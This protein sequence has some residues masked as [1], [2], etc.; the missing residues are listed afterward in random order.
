L[1]MTERIHVIPNGAEP[2]TERTNV[3]ADSPRIGFIG[4]FFFQPN[5]D[6]VKWF[7]RDIWPKIKGEFQHAQLRLIGRGSQGYLTKL[8]SDI[9]GLDWLDD[10]GD[11][12]ASWSVMIVPIKVGAGT[13]VKMAEG[14]AR[15]CPVVATSI[16]AFGYEVENG[17]EAFIADSADEFASACILL[18]RNPELRIALSDAAEKHFLAR[19]KWDLFEPTVGTVVRECLERAKQK[20]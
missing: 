13:R 15:R 6:G 4:N 17:R 16:G 5:E 19:W 14:F 8:G 9:I 18:L 10:P 3:V 12:I 20:S 1:G 11:E 2:Q 7:I